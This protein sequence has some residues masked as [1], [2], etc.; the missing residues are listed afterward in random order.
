MERPLICS[1]YH[2]VVAPI[3]EFLWVGVVRL[4]CH[5]ESVSRDPLSRQSDHA[6]SAKDVCMA[7]S[8]TTVQSVLAASMVAGRHLAERARVTKLDIHQS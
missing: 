4:G 8:N 5:C 7:S 2:C 1:D 3:F 6:S